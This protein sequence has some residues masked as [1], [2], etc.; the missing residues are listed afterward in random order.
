MTTTT[1]KL[2]AKAQL[3]VFSFL[4][5][6]TVK[7]H[8]AL[9]RL[10]GRSVHGRRAGETANRNRPHCAGGGG[11]GL[12]CGRDGGADQSLPARRGGHGGA[13]HGAQHPRCVFRYG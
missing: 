9:L 3:S 2:I 7:T 1:A 13:G 4:F 5:S 12:L 6:L 11:A 10:A 8:G